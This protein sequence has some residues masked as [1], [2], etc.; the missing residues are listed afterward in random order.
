MK[1]VT[2]DQLDFGKLKDRASRARSFVGY[3]CRYGLGR[4]GFSVKNPIQKGQCDCSGFASAMLG[5]SR[6]QEE[7]DKPWSSAIPWIE[8]TAIYNDA[9]G[10]QLLFVEVAEPVA[11][12][13]VVY[14]DRK[15]AGIRRQGHVGVVDL[16]ES[17]SI[18]CASG[19]FARAIQFR[20]TSFWLDKKR[21]GIVV[22]L[23]EDLKK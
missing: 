1:P 16:V 22:C 19:R 10:A 21:G 4:G 2:R 14:P 8:T 17:R 18:D 20:D 12:C 3:L 11:G 6:W 5:M 23:K 9:K 15:V 7:L 13:L